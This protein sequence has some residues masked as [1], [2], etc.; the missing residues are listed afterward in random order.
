MGG[1]VSRAIEASEEG[2]G[3][4]G[5]IAE[6]VGEV[7]GGMSL[8]RA[9]RAR[10]GFPRGGGVRGQWP[11]FFLVSLN[12]HP[13]SAPF[14]SVPDVSPPT[15]AVPIFSFDRLNPNHMA[16]VSAMVTGAYS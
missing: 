9:K 13:Y 4:G 8:E 1:S 11:K 10:K 12:M 15:M 16:V 5:G 3:G 2:F 7:P 6:V 14:P